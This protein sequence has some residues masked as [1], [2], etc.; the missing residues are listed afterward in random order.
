[1]CHP[2]TVWSK[3][4]T[5]TS[6]EKCIKFLLY[7]INPLVFAFAIY[8]KYFASNDDVGVYYKHQQMFV[9]RFSRRIQDLSFREI[10]NCDGYRS[11]SKPRCPQNWRADSHKPK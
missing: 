4:A 5:Y 3:M 6:V 7:Y 2:T 1:M 8:E 10:R 11:K 9:I